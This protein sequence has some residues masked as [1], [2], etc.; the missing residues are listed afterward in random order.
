MRLMET[1]SD[2]EKI[3]CI[4][5]LRL[6]AQADHKLEMAEVVL[7]NLLI[8]SL[9][10]AP[11]R[12]DEMTPD[13]LKA[14]LTAMD[15]EKSLECLRIGYSIMSI[16]HQYDPQ[17]LKYMKM[18]ADLHDIQILE[19]PRF[20]E[21]IIGTNDLTAL[22]KLVL[23]ALAKYVTLADGYI[24]KSKVEILVVLSDLM[25]IP[26]FVIETMDVPFNILIDAVKSMSKDA[27]ERIVEELT[28]IMI[29]DH[30]ITSEEYSLILP[31]LTAFQI[32]FNPMILTAR[33]RL[34]HNQ[35]YYKLLKSEGTIN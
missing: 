12:F 5:F 11:E 15:H 28:A 22:D 19:F 17:E 23:V 30:Q 32:D 13:E 1:Y 33:H 14:A 10:I 34:E 6:I 20:Y 4:N 24:K 3:A 2:R 21:S 16:N 35:E 26:P 29:A 7:I 8:L 31:I 27:V 25:G 9:G 18:L